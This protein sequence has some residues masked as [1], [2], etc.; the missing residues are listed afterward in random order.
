[1]LE[2]YHNMQKSEMFEVFKC[3]FTPVLKMSGLVSYIALTDLKGIAGEKQ[4][5]QV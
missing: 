4:I 3:L 5:K 1:M 2:N